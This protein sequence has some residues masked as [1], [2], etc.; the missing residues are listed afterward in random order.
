MACFTWCKRSSNLGAWDY[1]Q[2]IM[3]SHRS[4]NHTHPQPGD[5]YESM[6][7]TAA[8]FIRTSVPGIHPRYP[9]GYRSNGTHQQPGGYEQHVLAQGL[10][11]GTSSAPGIHLR[12]PCV[13]SSVFG[14]TPTCNQVTNMGHMFY[15][16]AW[17]SMGPQ[18]LEYIT[19]LCV[20][21]GLGN[22]HAQPGNEYGRHHVLFIGLRVGTSVLNIRY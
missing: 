2:S 11:M 7:Y 3:R 4:G 17:S 13:R 16:A 10:P 1:I 21:I 22:H 12:C 6:F 20:H 18:C 5:E 19:A 8:V 9:C 15:G 14:I